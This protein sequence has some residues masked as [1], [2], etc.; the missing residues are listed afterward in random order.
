[1]SSAREKNLEIMRETIR[2]EIEGFKR[3]ER[4][5]EHLLKF[6]QTPG[7]NGIFNSMLGLLNE[8]IF[9]LNSQLD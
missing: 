6:N 2:T 3:M 4:M 7:Y 9:E 8:K 1:M 5:F